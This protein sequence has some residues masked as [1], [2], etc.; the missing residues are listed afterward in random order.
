MSG[1][2]SFFFDVTAG[3]PGLVAVSD[4]GLW[5][6]V[7]GTTWSRV[8]TDETGQPVATDVVAN[9][10][11]LVAVGSNGRDPWVGTSPDG[12]S[13]LG[14]PN[15]VA[16]ALGSADEEPGFSGVMNGV[17]VGGPGLVAVGTVGPDAAVWTSAEVGEASPV[18]PGSIFRFDPVTNQGIAIETGL[19]AGAAGLG[20]AVGEGT[21]WA[22]EPDGNSLAQI[23]PGSNRVVKTVEI[24]GQGISSVAIG[25]ESVWVTRSLAGEGVLVETDSDTGRFRRAVSLAVRPALE[26]GY[27]DV[28][29]VATGAGAL[30]VAAA[31]SEGSML[32]RIN[33]ATGEVVAAIPLSD[34]QG[35]S[36]HVPEVVVG[37]G[38]VWVVG[39]GPA[40]VEGGRGT[41]WRIDPDTNE[42]IAAV[43]LAGPT[44]RST[45]IA[46][47]AGAVW[48][49][50]ISEST[51]FQIDPATSRITA[52]IPVDERPAGVAV[53]RGSVWVVHHLSPPLLSRI[54]PT[55]KQLIETIEIEGVPCGC[56][57]AVGSGGIWGN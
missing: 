21:V 5:A 20:V 40:D 38:A 46:V 23:D 2:G 26:L 9:G 12:V 48:V 27:F 31:G 7:D 18:A 44:S 41:V 34:E 33:P 22:F 53:R 24:V 57:I 19:T 42:V 16:A 54:D 17:T 52:S 56:S 49:A 45:S 11:G 1:E 28:M 47:G 50:D 3:G 39:Q 4:G 6:S 43:G 35:L 51:L 14:L 32:L 10:P 37:Q 55:T 13:W 25:E 15:G 29:S 8:P 36:D 30:W